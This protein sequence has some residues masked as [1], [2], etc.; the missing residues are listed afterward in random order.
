MVRKKISDRDRVQRLYD[1]V[2][3]EAYKIEDTDLKSSVE[4]AA[5]FLLSGLLHD[6]SKKSCD[7]CSKKTTGECGICRKGLCSSECFHK[8]QEANENCRDRDKLTHI[9]NARE[10][11]NHE[12]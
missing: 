1:H 2:Y 6:E 8:H 11:V 9:S 10:E 4:N 5:R 3:G 7:V 12:R